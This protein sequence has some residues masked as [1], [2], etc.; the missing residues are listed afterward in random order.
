MSNVVFFLKV[1]TKVDIS[2]YD[3]YMDA[4]WFDQ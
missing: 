2:R 1:E 3:R 4:L